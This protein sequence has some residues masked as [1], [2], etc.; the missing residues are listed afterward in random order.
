[1][2]GSITTKIQ[3]C[4]FVASVTRITSKP[5]MAVAKIQKI[6]LI[7]NSENFLDSKNFSI[8]IDKL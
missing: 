5:G 7:L 6:F 3:S 1:M 2:G 8:V 4:K